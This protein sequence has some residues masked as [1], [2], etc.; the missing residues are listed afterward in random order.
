M[1]SSQP[2]APRAAAWAAYG[3]SGGFL[4]AAL[5]ETHWVLAVFVLGALATAWL[6][7]LLVAAGRRRAGLRPAGVAVLAAVLVSFAGCELT[8]AGV[9]V[10][11]GHAAGPAR[12]ATPAPHHTASAPVASASSLTASWRSRAPAP[13]L[14]E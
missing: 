9:P 7:W 14:A 12:P 4:V 6:P 1:E 2:M 8:T 11:A 3:L 13:V 10:H 5:A